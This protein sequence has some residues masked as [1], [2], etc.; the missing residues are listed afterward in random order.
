M[1]VILATWKAEIGRIVIPGQL[2]QKSLRDSISMEKK[3]GMV[4]NAC[5]LSYGEKLKI[6]GLG[7]RSVWTKSET[8]SSK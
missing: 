2:G 4:V 5:H 8:L 6:G 7:S 1:P 3:L